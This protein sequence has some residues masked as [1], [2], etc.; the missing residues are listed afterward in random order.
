M[1]FGV[2]LRLREL[3]HIACP[4]VPVLLL[5][6]YFTVGGFIVFPEHHM[7]EGISNPVE[8]SF[9]LLGFEL[10][11]RVERLEAGDDAYEGWQRYH[12]H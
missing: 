3:H 10:H 5:V 11:R 9:V 12:R 2:A 7:V 1:R 6:V 8:I 4:D